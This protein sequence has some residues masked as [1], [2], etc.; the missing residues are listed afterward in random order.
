MYR[1][2]RPAERLHARSRSSNPMTSCELG[3]T[4]NRAYVPR[5]VHDLWCPGG[6]GGPHDATRSHPRAGAQANR[7]HNSI[8]SSYPPAANG[9]LTGTPTEKRIRCGWLSRIKAASRR[10]NERSQWGAPS[11]EL[12]LRCDPALL[13]EP[14]QPEATTASAQTKQTGANLGSISLLYT[15]PRRASITKRKMRRSRGSFRN[16]CPAGCPRSRAVAARQL[17]TGRG[18]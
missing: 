13:C 7:P 1:N 5:K 9:G 6:A 17:R 15:P 12:A 8:T 4:S 3:L 11:C 2:A 10:A 16:A 18:A 14:A